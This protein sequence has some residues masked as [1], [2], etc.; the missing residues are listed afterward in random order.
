MTLGGQA[1]KAGERVTM[2]LAAAN[3]D[4]AVFSEPDRLDLARQENRHMAFGQ[5]IHFCLGAPLA[6][7]E[8]EEVLKA[9]SRRLPDLRLDFAK[10]AQPEYRPSVVFRGLNELPVAW[11]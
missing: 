11:G 1:V 3:R 5:G 4:P 9:V 7:V 8:A 2:I 6:R 10:G